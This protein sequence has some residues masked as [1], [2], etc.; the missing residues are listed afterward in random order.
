MKSEEEIRKKIL[1]LN[2]V[3]DAKEK[4]FKEMAGK[5]PKEFAGVLGEWIVN[6]V[7]YLV[8]LGELDALKWVLEENG[9]SEY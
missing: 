1:E 2:S 4:Y 9:T 7:T 3:I 5:D 8:G 6:L